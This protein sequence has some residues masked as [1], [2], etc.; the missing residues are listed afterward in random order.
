ML[1]LLL[2]VYSRVLKEV[3]PKSLN[4]LLMMLLNHM[5]QNYVKLNPFPTIKIKTIWIV[6]HIFLSFI[7]NL[8]IVLNQLQLKSKLINHGS[9]A[10]DHHLGFVKPME[11]KELL[12]INILKS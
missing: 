1:I 4:P 6:Y 5:S 11:D 12:Y 10:Q 7:G 9:V 3:V 2:G 8:K